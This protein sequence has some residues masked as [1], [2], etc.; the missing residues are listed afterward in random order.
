MTREPSGERPL[1]RRR[2]VAGVL[3]LA[4]AAASSG[5]LAWQHLGLGQ[6]PGCGL[7][8][9]CERVTSGPWG[10]LPVLSWPV[11]FVGLAHFAALL[12]TWGL[13]GGAWP[14]TLTATTR[15][16]ALASLAFL[17]R[18]LADGEACAYCL[19]AHAANLVFAAAVVRTSRRT[20]TR[21]TEL[22]YLSAFV[23]VSGGLAALHT[24][25]ERA[26][27]AAEEQDLVRST[28]AL[29]SSRSATPFTGRYLRG[30]ATAAVRV[31]LFTDYQCPDCAAVE[32]QATELLGERSDLSLAVKHFPLCVECNV[33]A[34]ELG[35]NP[36]RNACWAARAAEAAGMLGGAEGFWRLHGWLFERRGA[37]DEATLR[38][39]LPGLG[40]EVGP[41]LA[42]L[43]GAETL[44]RV[45][46][47]VAEAL[48][49]GI[50]STPLIFVNGVELRGW[51]ARDGL[52]RGIE[53]RGRR[54]SRSGACRR[55]AA[56]RAREG[57]RGLA[58]R[59]GTGAG[60]RTRIEAG[61]D[62]IDAVVFG[63][64]LDD[65]TRD[66]ERRLR[67][68][69]AERPRVRLSF[70]H[71]PLDASCDPTL[72]DVH[73]GACLAAHAVEAARRVAGDEAAARAREWLTRA[74][75]APDEAVLRAA[76]PELELDPDAWCAALASPDV[77]AVVA[78]D[79]AEARR[80]DVHAIPQLF[81]AGKRVPRWRVGELPVLERILDEALAAR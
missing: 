41:F 81:V 63:D 71:F 40:F 76:A 7:E 12:V 50:D 28:E 78:E 62:A 2:R 39:A 13:A 1:G 66:L 45:E 34:R 35:R 21:R 18:M 73:P 15:L 47:D 59:T 14:A 67:A 22:G 20:D 42:L 32:A 33:R 79:L 37:F 58:P 19:T 75:R 80:L 36:H 9:P 26:R 53:G 43:R 56:G 23:L 6:L 8:S 69:A 16:G 51:R 64:V 46:A 17:G 25:G 60:G 31:V 54:H 4:V 27:T 70:R 55:S 11:A 49:V 61:G 5:A 29:R 68:L 10:T 38:A 52:R 44:R 24:V 65:V 57:A 30:P 72:P 77:H 48:D 74:A 3:L